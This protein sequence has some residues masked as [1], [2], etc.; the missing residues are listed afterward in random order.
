[1]RESVWTMYES[2]GA[3]GD[4]TSTASPCKSEG[5]HPVVACLLIPSLPNPSVAGVNFTAKCP[6]YPELRTGQ[7]VSGAGAACLQ[8][9]RMTGA[10]SLTEAGG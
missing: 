9:A 10:P 4:D 6:R 3:C 8:A 2:F 5:H 7:N 1:M